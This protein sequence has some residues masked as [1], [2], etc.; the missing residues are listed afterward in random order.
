MSNIDLNS[1]ELLKLIN[2]QWATTNDI[3]KI[4]GCCYSTALSERRAIESN[5]KDKYLRLPRYKVPMEE[6]VL[7]YGINIS[8]LKKANNLNK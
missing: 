6:V 4:M 1:A 5:I 3:M 2:K 7:Y 8:Y